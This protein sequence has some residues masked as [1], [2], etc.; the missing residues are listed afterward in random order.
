[1]NIE[2]GAR[3]CY[4]VF[5]EIRHAIRCGDCELPPSI[6]QIRLLGIQERSSCHNTQI[7]CYKSIEVY[8]ALKFSLF[9]SRR[10]LFVSY[11]CN[12]GTKI[13]KRLSCPQIIPI[14]PRYAPYLYTHRS[15]VCYPSSLG[16]SVGTVSLKKCV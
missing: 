14:L 9:C 15:D 7:W 10:A 12:L 1:M 3:S 16:W 4:S 13:S 6:H 11:T 2:I 5:M 8:S